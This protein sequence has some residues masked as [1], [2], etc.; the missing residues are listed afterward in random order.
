MRTVRLVTVLVSDVSGLD[1]LAVWGHVRYGSLGNRYGSFW[2]SLQVP[3][4]FLS[5]S[6]IGLEAAIL[7]I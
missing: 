2:A 7:T 3:D 6:V 1:G 5:D 4:F